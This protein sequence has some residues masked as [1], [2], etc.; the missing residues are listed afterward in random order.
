MNYQQNYKHFIKT[1]IKWEWSLNDEN[2]VIK[3]REM[4]IVRIKFLKEK[5]LIQGIFFKLKILGSKQKSALAST[6]Y[7]TNF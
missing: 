4:G 3:V 7:D 5:I 1:N 6:V 2:G